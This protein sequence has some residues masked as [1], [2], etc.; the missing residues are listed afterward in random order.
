VKPGVSI[1]EREIKM[2]RPNIPK[3][4]LIELT[5]RCNADC[6]MCPRRH[7][8]RP[9]IDM[10]IDTFERLINE[11]RHYDIKGLWLYN[12]G[13]P[14]LYPDISHV[15]RYCRGI[16]D[17]WLSTNGL[18]LT[19]EACFRLLDSPL[20]YLNISL[21]AMDE[22]TYRKMNPSGDFQLVWQNIH[23]LIVLKKKREK[24]RPLI[25]LQMIDHPIAKHQIPEFIQYW[26]KKVDIV[27]IN[28][29]EK[30]DQL[31][32]RDE[33]PCRRMDKG[34]LYIFS[35]G[36]VAACAT[37]INGINKVGNVHEQTIEEIWNSKEYRRLYDNIM[38]QRFDES[39]ICYRCADRHLA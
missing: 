9:E 18:L 23:R 13:E 2:T 11:I 7:M 1:L 20:D 8:T 32:I 28:Q 4:I 3:K 35:N 25:R 6:I 29:F 38:N 36:D 33:S 39:P 31:E 17:L 26:H 37:D 34:F 10:P 27:N 12:L 24:K 21:N 30:F 22:K 19:E 14:L 15:F 16:H 5:S